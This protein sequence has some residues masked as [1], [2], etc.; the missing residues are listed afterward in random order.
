[1]IPTYRPS[2][3]YLRETLGAL[4]AQAPAADRMQIEVVDDCSPDL[5]VKAMVASIA[6]ERVA[7]HRNDRNL[8]LADCWNACVQRARGEWVH[9]L[10]QDDLVFPGFYAELHRLI[11]AHPDAGAALTRH[12]IIDERS[13]WIQI[14]ALE[15][16]RPALLDDWQ[17]KLTTG[18]RLQCP[19]IVVRRKVYEEVGRFRSDLPY[20]LDWEMWARIAV[21]HRVA[22]TPAILAGY[23]EHGSSETAR[24][25]EDGSTLRDFIT[26]YR[27]LEARLPAER[28]PAA[29]TC[30]AANIATH[31][32]YKIQR[33]YVNGNYAEAQ[34][35]LRCSRFLPL[36]IIFQ[37]EVNRLRRRLYIKQWFG[38]RPDARGQTS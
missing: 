15:S 11:S 20:C 23:R 16:D 38:R 26:T 22:Y 29:R 7:F 35:L 31:L 9:L 8:G 30:F 17:F 33:F 14:S 13:A 12:S 25:Q 19:A 24:L 6:G 32:V 34:M 3:H 27:I 2:E 10:H 36:P 28:R 1:M 18:Q 4:L 37:N 5:D 21:S